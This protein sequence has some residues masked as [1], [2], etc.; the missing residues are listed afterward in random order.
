MSEQVR[1][2]EDHKDRIDDVAEQLGISRKDV[3]QGI[4]DWFF[5]E[6][7]AGV[8]G[9]EDDDVDVDDGVPE[10]EEEGE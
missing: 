3:L 10:E 8:L 4:L 6:A 1:I 7:G 5:S 2:S 9:G